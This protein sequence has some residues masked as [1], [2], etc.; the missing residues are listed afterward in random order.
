MLLILIRKQIRI[1]IWKLKVIL[2]VKVESYI[3]DQIM[4]LK[5]HLLF[6]VLDVK[7]I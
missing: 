1:R 3:Q 5:I 6:N 2:K 4:K 7:M